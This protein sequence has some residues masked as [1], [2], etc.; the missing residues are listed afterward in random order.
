MSKRGCEWKWSYNV[1]VQNKTCVCRRSEI[2][3]I[4]LN[5]TRH[6][7]AET[8][9]RPAFHRNSFNSF[10]FCVWNMWTERLYLLLLL[11]AL[12][13]ICFILPASQALDCVSSKLSKLTQAGCRQT[14]VDACRIQN[15]TTGNLIVLYSMFCALISYIKFFEGPDKCSWI[16][17]WNFIT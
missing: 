7:N 13:I 12:L 4:T 5:T 2:H 1:I 9:T 15:L 11:H 17:E 16:Y 8:S 14:N 6:S 10:F 3:G